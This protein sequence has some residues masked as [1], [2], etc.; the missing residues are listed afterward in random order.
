MLHSDT[1]AVGAQSRKSSRLIWLRDPKQRQGRRQNADTLHILV[2]RKHGSRTQRRSGA[3]PGDITRAVDR[4]ANRFSNEGKEFTRLRDE[5]NQQRRELPWEEVTKNY[6]FDGPDG[7]Q[8]LAALFESRSQLV[9]Y[10]FMFGP[11]WDAGCPHC[12]FWADNFNPIIV[13]LNQRDVSMV[14]I[15]RAPLGKIEE[16]KNRMGWNF[17]WLSSLG[18]DFN[19]DFQASFPPEDLNKGVVFYNFKDQKEKSSEREGASVFYKDST[20]KIFHTYSTYARGID[21]MNTAYNYLDLVPKGRDEGNRSQFWVRRHD[22]YEK[23]VGTD[24]TFVAIQENRAKK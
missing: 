19:L 21:L 2:E 6:V 24:R 20:G 11:D 15:S 23:S 17:K 5:L 8:T 12:S 14:A 3:T 9:V 18:N 16:Y 13:H 22:E 1:K 7:K 4:G 10:H